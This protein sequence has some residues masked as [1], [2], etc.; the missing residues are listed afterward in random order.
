MTER[1]QSFFFIRPIDPQW[2]AWIDHLAE[3]EPERVGDAE[4]AGQLTA[5]GS[6]WPDKAYRVH[7]DR[8]PRSAGGGE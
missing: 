5:F 2:K 1:A 8:K 6:R 3:T 4:H 7:V